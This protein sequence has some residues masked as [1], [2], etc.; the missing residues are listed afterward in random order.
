M[1]KRTDQPPQGITDLNDVIKY[2]QTSGILNKKYDSDLD[3]VID[4]TSIPLIPATQLGFSFA[5]ELAGK[6][7]DIAASSVSF[8][9]LSG[10]TDKIYL[11]VINTA[12]GATTED[13]VYL[14]FN[15]VTTVGNYGFISWYN[16]NGTTGTKSQ[17]SGATAGVAGCL[18]GYLP[19]NDII[20]AWGLIKYN[21]NGYVHTLSLSYVDATGTSV[22]A[23]N[24]GQFNVG[25]ADLTEITA[26]TPSGLASQW[27]A[28]LFKPKW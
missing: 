13:D 28:Y 24:G 15:G 6:L 1:R 11:L 3:G 20:T 22:I 4:L 14:Q 17:S 9:G 25:T 16:N 27:Y 8:T 21:S 10:K 2:M 5:W 23:V 26:F 12:T 7:E 19:G 18:F